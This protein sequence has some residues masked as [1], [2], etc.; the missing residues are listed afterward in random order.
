V[1]TI[2]VRALKKG[3][4]LQTDPSRGGS[5]KENFINSILAQS[6]FSTFRTMLERSPHS[7]AHNIVGATN[8]HM[9]SG[10]SPLD[11]IFW[12]HHC[13]V[14]RVWAQWQRPPGKHITP[15]L[16]KIYSGQFVDAS[17]KE[18]T[19]PTSANSLDIATFGYTY[20]LFES[21]QMAQRRITLALQSFET[22]TLFNEADVGASV[23]T[24]GASSEQK[25]VK[26]GTATRFT[27][28]VSNLVPKMFE[29]RTFWATNMLGVPRLAVES[30]RILAI[31]SDLSAPVGDG[32]FLVNVFINRPT[33]GDSSRNTR[34]QPNYDPDDLSHRSACLRLPYR[35]HRKYALLVISAVET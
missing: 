15:T 35:H 12:L 24:L 4:G 10:M 33:I 18:L 26:V 28:G 9:L 29:S 19:T 31:L 5:F 32:P 3:T 17:G 34:A 23:Q 22:Q 21:A 8:G 30:R 1:Q 27:V 16:D 6:D 7:N 14:D 20:D 11:P 25:S 2:G 13:N